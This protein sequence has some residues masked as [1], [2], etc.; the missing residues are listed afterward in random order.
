MTAALCY[1]LC[2]SQAKKV[3]E[4]FNEHCKLVKS[5]IKLHLNAE[6][7]QPQLESKI[8]FHFLSEFYVIIRKKIII[9]TL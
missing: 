9:S 8:H 7:E 2:E 5:W 1:A 6:T 3:I 4:C